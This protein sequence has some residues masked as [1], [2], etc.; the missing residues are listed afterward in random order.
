MHMCGAGIFLNLIA[1]VM[2]AGAALV[3]VPLV[4][5]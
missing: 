1:T 3:L 2:I 4:F 5:G